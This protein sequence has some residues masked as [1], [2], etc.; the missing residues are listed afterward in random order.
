MKHLVQGHCDRTVIGISVHEISHMSPPAL[1]G[2]GAGNALPKLF[3]FDFGVCEELF[4]LAI[5]KNR[6]VMDSMLLKCFLQRGPDRIMPSFIF[7]LIAR[8]QRHCKCF[9]NHSSSPN[10]AAR[11]SFEY[12]G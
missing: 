7:S 11:E 1:T 3:R 5:E 10:P 9:A 12:V 2:L 4:T 8:L 6:V